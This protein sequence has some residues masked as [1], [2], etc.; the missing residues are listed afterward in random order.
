MK[1]IIYTAYGLPNVLHL[2]DLPTPEPRAKEVR[3][4]ICSTSVNSADWRLRKPDPFLVRLVFGLFK[5]R[6]PIL[7]NTF[8]GV[9]DKI[10]AEVTQYK[11]GAE[12][13]GLTDMAMGTYAEYTCRPATDSMALKPSNLTHDEAATIPFGGHTALHFLKEVSW[14]PGMSVLIYGASGAVGSAALQIAKA[15]GAEVT[16]VCSTA[17]IE[18]VKSLG[19][20]HVIDYIKDDV[21]KCKTRFDVIM[22]TVNKAAIPRLA[23]LLKPKS[24]LILSAAMMK[25]TIQGI[26]IGF[27]GHKVLNGVAKITAAGMDELRQLVESGKLKPVVDRIYPLEQMATAHTYVEAG[28]KKGN[29][30]IHIC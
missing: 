4:K 8:S 23:D 30:A 27:K 2:A 11:V 18:L 3:I 29:V 12:V 26:R 7:G 20:D 22:E 17:N 1:A 14:K 5:P 28:H 10:G 15:F 25:E 6:N 16:A 9:I 19:A 13:F 21:Y 24:T